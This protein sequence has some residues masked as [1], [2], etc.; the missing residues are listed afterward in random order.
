[1][2]K[3]PEHNY[4]ISKTSI[5]IIFNKN[6]SFIKRRLSLFCFII[7]FHIIKLDNSYITLRLT[8]TGNKAILY[9]GYSIKPSEV[10]IDGN[11]KEIL[12]SYDVDETNIIKLKFNTSIT[13]CYMMFFQCDSIIEINFTN[14]DTS[15]CAN[16]AKMF[17]ECKN[18]KSL[19]LSSFNTSS[20]YNFC[21]MFWDCVKL[22]SLNV[23]SFDTNKAVNM[24]HMFCNCESLISI[25]ISN[26]YVKG[27]CFFDNMFNGCKAIKSIYFPNFDMSSATRMNDIFLSC[28]NLEYINIQNYKTDI[29]LNDTFF[30]GTTKN[31]S[32]CIE[33][34]ELI[35]IN[36]NNVCERINCLD[37]SINLIKKINLE[38]NSCTSNCSLVNYNYEYNDKCYES[39]LNHTFYDNFKCGDC[40][41]DCE[42]CEGPST[43]NSSNCKTCKPEKFYNYGNCLNNCSRGFYTNTTTN[44]NICK[45][46][47][48]QC[49]T[50]SQESLNYNLCTSCENG[51]FPIYDINNTYYPFLNCSNSPEGYYLDNETLMYKICYISCKKCN[52]SGND[53]EH[54]CLECK[55]EYNFEIHFDYYK[56]CYDNCSYY[57][58]FDKNQNLS[59][60]TNDS[61]C[62]QYYD[63]LIEDKRECVFN[64][65]E[66]EN[67]N[68][69]FQK[70]CY[71][72][73]P[74]NSTERENSLELEQYSF[75]N[76]YFCKPI[77]NEENPFEKIYT[78]ECIKKCDIKSYVNKSCIINYQGKDENDYIKPYNIM[79]KMLEEGFT[80]IDYDTSDLEN[81]F[82]NI[83]KYNDLTITL[84]TTDIQKNDKKNGNV[85][86]IDLKKCEY[87]LKDA[88]NISY[89][90]TLFIKKIDVK[91][92]GMLIP[93]IEFDVYY[94]L[95]DTNLIKLNL[96]YCTDTKIDIS[97]P[98]KISGNI[99]IHNSSSGYYNDLCY[100]TKSDIGTDIT[101]KDRKNEF[102]E[103]NK[104]VCQDNCIFTEYD[105]IIHK[106]KC[107]CDVIESSSNFENM[108][109][110]RKN[111]Y[112][113][114]I[115]IKNIANINLLVCY[116]ELFTI[117]GIIKNY[118]SYSIITI[119]I[120]HL[121]IILIFYLKNLYNNIKEKINEIS[122]CINNQ[123]S[124][125]ENKKNLEIIADSHKNEIY[126]NITNQINNNKSDLSKSMKHL[127]I[128]PNVQNLNTTAGVRRSKYS[129]TLKK[130]KKKI[131]NGKNKI[132]NTINFN[133]IKFEETKNDPTFEDKSKHNPLS[134]KNKDKISDKI[135]NIMVYNDEELNNLPY[136]EAL[137]LDKRNY[138]EYYFSL[139]KTKHPL[140]FT[141]FN[142]TDYNSTII[143]INLFIFNFSLFFAINTL[144][145]SDDTMHKI[146]EDKGSFNFLY[147]LPQIIYSSLISLI[148]NSLL[149]MLALTEGEISELKKIKDKNEF[150]KRVDIIEIKIK[151]KFVIYFILSTIFLMF[152][153]Y[154]ISI[155]C[156]IYA[157][158]QIHLIKDTLLSFVLSQIDPF[159]FYLLP[160]IFRIPSLSN[161]N[162]KQFILYKFSTILQVIFL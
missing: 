58:Y 94:K 55:N 119:I 44:Q 144:F 70:K 138:C 84:T 72:K 37:T 81:G 135:K 148:F 111:L 10:F 129:N 46:E 32:I 156:S 88:Y 93:K 50:C 143:K 118:G 25:D 151:I 12:N 56:N 47:L 51:S 79:L 89:N 38:D 49:F 113:N 65:S 6:K 117:K 83:I 63:K 91:Q 99:D 102:I 153:W 52:I 145:F 5:F 13:D 35:K 90:E 74:E 98:V 26:F 125:S 154:Y 159:I 22:E 97:I 36:D 69:E 57:Y 115:D 17:K 53:N 112:K 54:N 14:F 76:K 33:K 24:G 62:P 132:V 162:N 85:T 155:F 104:T 122:F 78:Q 126:E 1:M 149:E 152:F 4:I 141:F 9:S 136:E 127:T 67:Y 160:G 103:N 34:M 28:E 116:K 87:L 27:V 131:H 75:D 30:L 2:K 124:N 43:V 134:S 133:N 114:F 121:I 130:K 20:V 42:E 109:I 150:N 80:S 11:P 73:C 3:I 61:K 7:L 139:L 147:Q 123:D 86:T 101:L 68:Y 8:S 60:C 82:N 21:D 100:K 48:E 59:F 108:K 77:C 120:G 110:E 31:V 40:H 96:S 128:K 29:A 107:S 140:L 158:T 18:L 41:P 142:N 16:M 157:H 105:N 92:H 15:L 19:D 146:Y 161:S 95:N 23:S 45:C 106:A 71:N 66:N 39:C 64:C 137:K